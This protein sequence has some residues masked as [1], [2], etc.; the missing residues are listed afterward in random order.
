VLIEHHTIGDIFTRRFKAPKPRYALVISH[1]IGAHSGVY[2]KFGAHHGAR[3]VD[4]WAYDAPGHG[5]STAT[6]PRGQFQFQE[7][8]D[9]CIAVAKQAKA[10]TGLPVIALG[11]SLGVAAS[12]SSLHH[13]VFDGAVLMGSAAVPRSPG[14]PVTSPFRAPEVA[15]VAKILG[16]SLRF[17]INSFID[18]EKDYGFVGARDQRNWDP[19]NLDN[20]QFDAF[21]SLVSHD[22][23][24]PPERNAKPILYAY[25]ADDAMTPLSTVKATAEAIAG[26]VR[27]EIIPGGKHQLMLFN[28]EVFSDLL[29]EWVAPILAKRKD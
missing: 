8:V 14:M 6:R 17:D 28:T 24:V 11:S 7:W 1:G 27:F 2:N 15:M 18:F 13:D 12:F 10:E 5:L 4:I 29:E 20:Y 3:G 21:V 16:R 19:M 23:V 22:P 25:G 9:A 26:P